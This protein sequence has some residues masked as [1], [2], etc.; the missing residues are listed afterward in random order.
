M[1]FAT[2]SPAWESRRTF[3]AISKGVRKFFTYG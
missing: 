3:Y 1:T 2:V